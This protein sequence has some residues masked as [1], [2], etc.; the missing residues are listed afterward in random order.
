MK[1]KIS[2]DN[3]QVANVNLGKDTV[4]NAEAGAMIYKSGN[5]TI[6]TETKGIS[7][8]L[9]R[10]LTGESLFLTKFTSVGGSGLVG[11]AGKF[12]G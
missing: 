11:F 3:L 4:V 8:A 9:K 7:K 10:V 2:G 6:D 5:V 1:Y 12:P